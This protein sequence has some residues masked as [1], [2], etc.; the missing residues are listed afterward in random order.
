MPG[1]PSRGDKMSKKRISPNPY[2]AIQFSENLCNTKLWIDKADELLAAA[3]IL[4]IEVVK[5]WQEIRFDGTIPIH[6]PL[7]KLVQ[8]PFFLL[9]AYALENYF[10]ALLVNKNRDSFRNRLLT[11]IPKYID[12]HDLRDLAQE[13]GMKLTV[14]EQEL[15]FRLSNHSVWVARYPVPRGPNEIITAQK[16]SDGKSRLTAYLGPQDIDRIH[17]FIDR[18]QELVEK[19]IGE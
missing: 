14:P 16:F 7:R 2:R 18:C 5:Y 1:S 3:K 15:L 8:S 9:I 4:E 6:A 19:E 12:K 17:R 10:K 11:K 13:V